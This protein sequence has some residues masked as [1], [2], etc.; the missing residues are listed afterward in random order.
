MPNGSRN[1][2]RVAATPLRDLLAETQDEASALGV[3]VKKA[4]AHADGGEPHLGAP[5][6][7]EAIARAD[8]AGLTTWRV[9]ARACLAR[10][11]PEEA[12][13]LLGDAAGIAAEAEEFNLVSSVA[14]AARELGVA[15]PVEYGPHGARGDA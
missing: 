6:A 14:H 11:V 15:L 10:C 4:Q 12:T 1:V 5:L 8:A 7:R 9:F 2:R 13:S 3:Y